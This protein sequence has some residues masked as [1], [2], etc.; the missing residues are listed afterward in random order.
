FA[1]GGWQV[2]GGGIGYAINDHLTAWLG[3]FGA[4]AAIVFA[5]AAFIVYTFNP[6]FSW[7]TALFE[8]RSA[9]ETDITEEVPAESGNRLRTVAEAEE[10][11][12]EA[13]WEDTTEEE[14]EPLPVEAPEEAQ[15]QFEAPVAAPAE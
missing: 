2:L 12:D 8:R 11:A 9:V 6:S 3:N 13:P 4:G 1:Q 5:A 7:I 10:E 15:L 14:E